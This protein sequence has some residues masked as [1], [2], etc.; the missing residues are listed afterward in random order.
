VD[1]HFNC[2]TKKDAS[3][4]EGLAAFWRFSSDRKSLTESERLQQI[5]RG[6]PLTLSGLFVWPSTFK[7]EL[8]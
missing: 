4:E 1:E 7:T 8:A 2:D 5:K 6:G 3:R